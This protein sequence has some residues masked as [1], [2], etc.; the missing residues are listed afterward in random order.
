MN[1]LLL[2]QIFETHEDT[3]SDRHF[4][5]AK[6]F[7][8]AGH[9]VSVI[10]SNF[11]Y[12]N[13][14]KRFASKGRV[15]V[16]NIDR[17]CVKYISVYDKIRGS[18]L[19]RILFFLSF[20]FLSIRVTWNEARPDVV[21]AV[22]TPLTVGLLGVL[23]SWI[24]RCPLVFEVT[25]VWPDAAIH[26]GVVKNPLLIALARA[27]E[28]FCYRNASSI[29]CLT[30]GI[31]EIITCKGV[32]LR[33][34]LLIPNGVDPAL[35]LPVSEETRFDIRLKYGL[36]NK[37]VLMYLGAHG[38]YNSL[39]TIILCAEILKERD[40]IT[41]VLVGDGELKT[42]LKS[43][44]CKLG[45]NNI[46]F[47]GTVPRSESV[48][49]LSASDAFLLPNLKGSFFECNLPN[50]LFDFLASAKPIIV[51][52]KSESSALVQDAGAGFVVNSR[53]PSA[54]A[55]VVERTSLLSPN[56]LLTLGSSGRDYV[57]AHYNRRIQA[58]YLLDC[59]E[60]KA[61]ASYHS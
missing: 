2:V 23:T 13:A 5:F 47:L 33:R 36:I 61:T 40:D 57:L 6:H 24:H 22:S 46:I 29:V 42:M 17:I 9:D 18:L 45:L 31:Q 1:I 56:E 50:K 35:F 7:A 53:D 26:T 54:L 16:R 48:Q 58:Q 4:Y 3:G 44:A 25:D 39:D 41:F 37:F 28:M 14:R 59:L 12:K 49:L 8:A 27:T 21:Y 10:T 51:S 15:L 38:V 20:F 55:R 60:R 43:M 30:K 52:G 32:D 19:K 34:T 11:D